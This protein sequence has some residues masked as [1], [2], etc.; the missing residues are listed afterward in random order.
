MSKTVL[1][2][3]ATS[4]LGRALAF[5]LAKDGWTV[6]AHGRSPQRCA[7]LV[8]SLQSQGADARALVADFDSLREVAR[9][10]DETARSVESLDLL[11]NNAGAGAGRSGG[12]RELTADGYERR[13]AVNFLAPVCLTG[14]LAGVLGAAPQRAQVMNIGSV[15]MEPVAFDD[16]HLERRYNGMTA[17][18]RSKFALA[19]YTFW[20]AN[21]WADAVNVNCVHPATY[22]DTAMVRESGVSPWTSVEDGCRATKRAIEDGWKNTA[23]FYDGGRPGRA[24]RQAY[25]R[26]TQEK[27]V[28][29]ANRLIAEATS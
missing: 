28:G 24:H 13:L 15:G 14:A 19:A 29:L 12:G 16:P 27:V 1:I 6:L 10:G 17:Y 21:R 2:T 18:V 3:G 20:L 8:A 22:M 7:D 5:S 4:G 9:L 23:V 26:D 25:D 11:V